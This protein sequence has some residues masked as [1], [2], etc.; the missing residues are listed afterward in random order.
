MDTSA[1]RGEKEVNVRVIPNWI[2][3]EWVQVCTQ[4]KKYPDAVNNIRIVTDNERLIRSE[5]N[6]KK[7]LENEVDEASGTM[8]GA[9]YK[10]KNE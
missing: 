7:Q 3:T 6:H 2:W 4:L 8:Y 9:Y 10:E 1:F 5:W